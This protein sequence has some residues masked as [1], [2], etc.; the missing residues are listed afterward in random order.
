MEGF[1]KNIILRDNMTEKSIEDKKE[2]FDCK[3]DDGN[4]KYELKKIDDFTLEYRFYIT[5]NPIDI[6]GYAFWVDRTDRNVEISIYSKGKEMYEY[7]TRRSLLD[8]K[9]FIEIVA[10][11]PTEKRKNLKVVIKSTDNKKINVLE[12]YR[13]IAIYHNRYM[14]IANN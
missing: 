2:I 8:S 11:I 3:N 4:V 7:Y 6:S 5:K 14:F 9:L 1:T 10:D 12:V 13:R